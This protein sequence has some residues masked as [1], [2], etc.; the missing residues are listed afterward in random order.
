MRTEL[1]D[2]QY[3]RYYRELI[4]Y[5]SLDVY[6][7]ITVAIEAGKTPEWAAQ[8]VIH[9]VEQCDM[10]IEDVD[11][12]YVVYEGILQEV[13]EDIEEHTKWDL[14]NDREASGPIYTSGN[15]CATSYDYSTDA[16]EELTK[17]LAMEEI[18]IEDLSEPTQWFLKE[19][20]IKQEDIDKYIVDENREG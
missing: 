11:P 20:G 7:A 14:C 5:G 2:A 16:I 15:Y 4:P 12:V 18:Q 1:T 13:R 3:E 6:E 17:I 9:Y 8:Q 10:K 19:I